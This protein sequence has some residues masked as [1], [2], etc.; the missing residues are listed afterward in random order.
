MAT[1]N[2]VMLIVGAIVVLFGIG[3]FL[4][5]NIARWVN[6]PG[7]PRLKAIIS[8]IIGSTLV[9]MSLVIELPTGG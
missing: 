1:V 7:G 2:T 3:A 9:I 8:L 4:H 6:A 5:P